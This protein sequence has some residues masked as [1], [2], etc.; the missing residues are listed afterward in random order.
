MKYVYIYSNSQKLLNV[1]NSHISHQ[2][3]KINA[4]GRYFK[5]FLNIDSIM[6]YWPCQYLWKQQN[7]L[8]RQFLSL[9]FHSTISCN[10]RNREIFEKVLFF[11]LEAHE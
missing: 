4:H 9:M 1:K 6:I 3:H 8:G 5:Y 7:I 11:T 10:F 2:F